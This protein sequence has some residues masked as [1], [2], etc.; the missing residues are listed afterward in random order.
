MAQLAASDAGCATDLAAAQAA[1]REAVGRS[2]EA[3]ARDEAARARVAA[4]QGTAGRWCGMASTS[5]RPVRCRSE[6]GSPRPRRGRRRQRGALEQAKADR[7]SMPNTEFGAL[8]PAR[9]AR[10][11]ELLAAERWR[12]PSAGSG[13]RPRNSGC[14]RFV[15]AV[16]RLAER[17]AA[18]ERV[19]A[20]LAE[21][22][23]THDSRAELLAGRGGDGEVAAREG[24][25]AMAELAL[26]SADGVLDRRA[27]R[28]LPPSM[29]A[30]RPRRNCAISGARPMRWRPR[31]GC[32]KAWC[33]RRARAGCSI[34]S[35]CRKIS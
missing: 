8:A 11:A 33:R 32:W 19:V 34:A 12:R 21:R 2:A 4:L 27:R 26:A 30:P 18:F 23:S 22:R 9:E 16:A 5:C 35:R 6:R 20:R 14:A 17:R 10:R 15:R 28:S 1:L 24:E 29:P 25:L 7:G 13:S 3:A 31:S